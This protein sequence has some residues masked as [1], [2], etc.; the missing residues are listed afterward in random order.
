MFKQNKETE[1]AKGLEEFEKKN[2]INDA[3]YTFDT[4]KQEALREKEPWKQE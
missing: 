2:Q 3:N 4:E 1:K